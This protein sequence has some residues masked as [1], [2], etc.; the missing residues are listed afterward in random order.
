MGALTDILVNEQGV[1][2]RDLR[3]VLPVNPKQAWL[4]RNLWQVK[5]AIIPRD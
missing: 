5:G 3:T 2:L 1:N 4:F